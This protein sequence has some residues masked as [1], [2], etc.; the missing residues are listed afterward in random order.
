MNRKI[1][2]AAALSFALSVASSTTAHAINW[3][4]NLGDALRVSKESGKPV[5]VDFYTDWCGWC[6]K[7][8]SDTYSSPK[9]S[10]LADKFVCVKINAERD[11]QS[12]AKY[13][14]TGYPTILFLDG[15]GN[16]L[17][18][19]PGYQPPDQFA[20]VMKSV[21]LLMPQPEPKGETSSEKKSGGFV[22]LDD[23]SGD[24]KVKGAKAKTVKQEFVFNG[25]V[26]TPG[27]ELIAQVNYKGNTYFVR[28]GEAF[29][30]FQVIS[31]DKEKV[32]LAG[33][34]G[35]IVL[36]YKKP[37]RPNGA[38]S[39]FTSIIEEVTTDSDTGTAGSEDP[40]F[41][42]AAADWTRGAA[43]LIPIAIFSFIM[44]VSYVY[45]AL[46]LQF[47]AKKTN[48]GNGW[49][50]WIPVINLFLLLNISQ[51]RYRVFFLPIIAFIV[52]SAMP[53]FGPIS[54]VVGL[55]LALIMMLNAIYFIFLAAYIWY[56]VA[57]IRGKSTALSVVLAIL[58]FISPLNAVAL[59]YLAFSK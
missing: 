55:I 57:K 2:L 31:A 48:T 16:V 11:T 5:M 42:A 18:R 53:A 14:V 29:A 20:A 3:R 19:I 25:Y 46:C 33:E 52:L 54:P 1:V 4:S 49:M 44:I 59:G 24:K 56:K 36:E 12:A 23:Q 50:A 40:S 34:N 51:L 35:E 43:L 41:P 58:M 45:Y 10:S 39:S 8:D 38:V 15:K 28:K 17:Q 13:Q 7:L 9:V 37:F 30:K 22:V 27:E 6:K 21:L 32:V 26:E 47:I